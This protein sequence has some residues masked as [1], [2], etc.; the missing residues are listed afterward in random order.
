MSN[1]LNS[2][3]KLNSKTKSLMKIPT[4]PLNNR[5]LCNRGDRCYS[6]DQEHLKEHAKNLRLLYCSVEKKH[7]LHKLNKQNDKWICSVDSNVF[8]PV[9]ILSPLKCVYNDTCTNFSE[10]HLSKMYHDDFRTYS[11]GVCQTKSKF[12][13][14]DNNFTCNEC[15]KQYSILVPYKLSCKYCENCKDITVSHREEY[16]H[17]IF[18]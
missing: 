9:K 17:P 10:D 8:Y 12:E 3:Q 2:A 7:V 11:C 16:S 4:K 15:F 14:R 6:L 18:N 1:K 5:I 13:M